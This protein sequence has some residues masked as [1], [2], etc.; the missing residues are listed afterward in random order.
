MNP[1]S[2]YFRTPPEVAHETSLAKEKIEELDEDGDEH[3]SSSAVV[4][5]PPPPLVKLTLEHTSLTR[6]GRNLFPG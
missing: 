4:K 5:A 3:H 1:I 2:Y 6:H